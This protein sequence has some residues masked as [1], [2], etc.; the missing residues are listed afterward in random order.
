[1]GKPPKK[2]FLEVAREKGNAG[3][4]KE[5]RKNALLSIMKNKKKELPSDIEEIIRS[6]E[7]FE[8]SDI[9]KRDKLYLYFTQCGKCMYSGRPIDIGDIGTAVD[10]L[11]R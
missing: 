1:M 9:A 2:V 5:S 8:E 11:L 4:R 3:E 10:V 7:S 6:L